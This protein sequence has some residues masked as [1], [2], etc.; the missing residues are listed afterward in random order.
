MLDVDR[1]V[2]QALRIS[3][4]TGDFT[5]TQ[6]ASRLGVHPSSLYHHIAGRDE[7]IDLMRARIGRTI[8]NSAFESAPWDEAMRRLG[9]SYRAAFARHAGSIRLLA[10]T[11]VRD[12]E[13]LSEYDRMAHGLHAAGFGWPEVLPIIIAFDNFV[14]GSAL[15]TASGG[16]LY[17]ADP[18]L[19]P[20]LS[21]AVNDSEGGRSPSE[22]AFEVGLSAFLT[23]LRH[24][25]ADR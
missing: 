24:K 23:G 6:L 11:L 19:H 20:A 2:D 5:I 18:Q 13:S 7:V 1:I 22:L 16:N 21:A 10:T 14:L 4:T 12:K 17:T 9:W 3:D 25:L 8:D 15:D